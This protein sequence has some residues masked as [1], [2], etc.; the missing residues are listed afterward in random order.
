MSRITVILVSTGALAAVVMLSVAAISRDPAAGGAKT[1]RGTPSRSGAAASSPT[2]SRIVVKPGGL[3][4]TTTLAAAATSAPTTTAAHGGAVTQAAGAAGGAVAT[5]PVL[6]PEF[7]IF[8]TRSPFAKGPK[9]PPASAPGGPEASFVLK[10][11][12][13]VGGRLTAFVEDLSAKRVVQLAAGEPIARGRIKGITL[14]A[15]EYEAAGTPAKR[16]EVGQNLM[17][18]VVPPTPTSKPAAGPPGQPGAPGQPGGPPQPGMPP[19]AVRVAPGQPVPV[20][21]P[22]K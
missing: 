8:Q 11:A 17:G 12:V 14:D 20:P 3:L 9:K 16:I 19:G 18:Q 2:S 1:E 15:I 4:V 13:D 7:A 21:A 22:G 10:G 5:A 6:P